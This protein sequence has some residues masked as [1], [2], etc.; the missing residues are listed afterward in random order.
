MRP[1]KRLLLATRAQLRLLLWAAGIIVF[2]WA[3]RFVWPHEQPRNTEII[4]FADA[5]R[6]LEG[7]TANMT[8]KKLNDNGRLRDAGKR[9]ALW[10]ALQRGGTP[11]V[12]NP[13]QELETLLAEKAKED[14]VE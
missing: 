10:E 2:L 4:D 3:L 9:S 14:S 11:M 8:E 12:I 1:V 7:R 13:K 6:K 5:V